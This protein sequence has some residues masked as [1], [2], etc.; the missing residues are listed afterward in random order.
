[1]IAGEAP[2]QDRAKAELVTHV[3]G[4]PGAKDVGMGSEVFVEGGFLRMFLGPA[5]SD[6]CL[7]ML[8]Y[9]GDAGHLDYCPQLNSGK[10][11]MVKGVINEEQCQ[12]LFVSNF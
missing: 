8:C 9:S 5:L 6:P 11:S 4:R 3:P 7:V 2:H 10:V 1:M 12:S